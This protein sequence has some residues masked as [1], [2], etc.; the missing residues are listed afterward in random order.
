[1]ATERE[2]EAAADALFVEASKERFGKWPTVSPDVQELWRKSA[3]AALEA[4]ER[5]R[6]AEGATA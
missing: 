4:A 1:M 6:Q 2:I 5:V 3:R